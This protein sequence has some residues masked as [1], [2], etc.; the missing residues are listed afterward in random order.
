MIFNKKIWKTKPFK[1]KN[2]YY[3]HKSPN[4]LENKNSI[5]GKYIENKTYKNAI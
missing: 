2:G 4:Y 3:N 1:Y 5:N